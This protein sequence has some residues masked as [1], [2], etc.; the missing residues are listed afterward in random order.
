MLGVNLMRVPPQ[1][2]INRRTQSKA[3]IPYTLQ[4]G[5]ISTLSLLHKLRPGESLQFLKPVI[6][7]NIHY[8]LFVCHFEVFF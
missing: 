5:V 7:R 2:N 6:F 1:I 4:E 3:I 8:D